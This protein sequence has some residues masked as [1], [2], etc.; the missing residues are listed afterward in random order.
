M[1]LV[2]YQPFDLFNE[3]QRD[4]NRLFD[5]PSLR[6]VSNDE[7]VDAADW[8]PAVDIKEEQNRYLLHADVPGVKAED[9]DV[10][11]DRGVLTIQGKRESVREEEKEG[12]RRVERAR[13]TFLR[14]FNLPE[15][16]DA[17]G[18]TAKT[19]DGVLEVEIPKSATLQ[20]RK[21]AVNP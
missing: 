11:M 7:S 1:T 13:G 19:S 15:G 10:T 6:R 9:I 2:R 4:I 21:I 3:L 18:I 8:A 17:E 5:S 16:V 20:P 12:Y 14:R